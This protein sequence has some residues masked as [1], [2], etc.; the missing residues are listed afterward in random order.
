MDSVLS[1]IELLV[2][3]LR[4]EHKRLQLQNSIDARAQHH[5]G[6]ELWALAFLIEKLRLEKIRANLKERKGFEY[7]RQL[8]KAGFIKAL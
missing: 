3:K 7:R 8:R 4:L 6:A 2:T 1:D 5:G